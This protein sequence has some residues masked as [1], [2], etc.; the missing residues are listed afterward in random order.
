MG[1]KTKRKIVSL[2]TAPVKLII[3][4][5]SD[6]HCNYWYLVFGVTIPFKGP[7]RGLSK[8]MIYFTFNACVGK[9]NKNL[10]LMVL[11]HKGSLS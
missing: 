11:P 5:E 4:I 10:C 9:L 6:T 2:G 7:Q 8:I 1:K 3:M